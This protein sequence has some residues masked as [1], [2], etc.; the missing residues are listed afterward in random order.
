M[1]SMDGRG[2]SSTMN[3]LD[4]V[5]PVL[6]RSRRFNKI[7]FSIARLGGEREGFG[8]YGQG[9]GGQVIDC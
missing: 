1:V 7:L 2:Q 4:A 8:D 6:R 9:M 5:D 3:H